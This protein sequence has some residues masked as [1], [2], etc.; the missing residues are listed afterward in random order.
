MQIKKNCA[1][2][3]GVYI[4]V[5]TSLLAKII[6]Q[7]HSSPKYVDITIIEII[8]SIIYLPVTLILPW[9]VERALEISCTLPHFG[10]SM[11]YI[12][13]QKL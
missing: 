2:D 8:L 13:R 12:S 10:K 9:L 5:Y 6:L 7:N 3:R 11:V 4:H 1:C